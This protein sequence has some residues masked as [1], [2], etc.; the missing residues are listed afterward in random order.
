MYPYL[1]LSVSPYPNSAL[2]AGQ[3]VIIAVVPVLSQA[4]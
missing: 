2:F 3:L 1:A 4:A